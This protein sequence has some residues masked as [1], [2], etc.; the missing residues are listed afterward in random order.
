MI[1]GCSCCTAPSDHADVH[2]APLREL[3]VD[4]LQY[5]VVSAV[6]TWGTVEDFK[7][8]L[9]RMFELTA[10]DGFVIPATETLYGRLAYAEFA[11]WP[12][13]EQEAVRVFS[14][15]HLHSALVDDEDGDDPEAVLTGVMLMGEELT[16]Y[17][18]LLGEHPEEAAIL[19]DRCAGWRNG[20]LTEETR[21]AEQRLDDW[22]SR[23][24]N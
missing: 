22:L 24:P 14:L 5:F 12:P 9:P 6:F 20:Y 10:T 4:Q 11:T 21:P 8:F 2:A 7:H 16:P 17:L 19:R 18:A 23:L 13:A 15:A 3:N 1:D